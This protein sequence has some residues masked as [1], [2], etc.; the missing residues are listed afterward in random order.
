MNGTMKAL[1]MR[2]ADDFGV[3]RVDVPTSEDNEALVRIMAV[4]ICGSDPKILNGGY[5]SINWPPYFPFTPGHEFAGEGGSVG[6]DVSKFKPGDRVAGEAHCGCGVCENCKDGKYNLCLNYGKVDKGHRHYGFTY[7]GAYAEYNAYD[8]KSLTML[9]DNVSFEEGSLNDTA[10]TALHAT[11]LTGVKKDG[12]SLI[13]GPGPIGLFVMQIA[14]ALGS[15]TIMVGR[16]DR[17]EF[18][19]KFG[20]DFA[21]N[22]EDVEDIVGK[23]KEI[24]NGSGVDQSFECAGTEKAMQQCIYATRKDGNVAFVSLPAQDLHSIPTKTMVMNQIHLHGS[25]ANPN[26]STEVLDLMHKGEINAKQMITHE[27][28]LDEIKHALDIFVNRLDGVMKVV[29][30]PNA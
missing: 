6:T 10:G 1:V 25:R 15:K 20:A 4:S 24:T 8:E 7:R 19:K 18:A 14:K 11:R 30:K 5:A 16:R 23:V 29:I 21:I 12:F 13:V 22:Y 27:L 17:L 9:P 2:G 26:C 28:P 3:E